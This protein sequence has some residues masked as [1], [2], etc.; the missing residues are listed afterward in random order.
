MKAGPPLA[1]I[2]VPFAANTLSGYPWDFSYSRRCG[3]ESQEG[4]RAKS[5]DC[6]AK[7]GQQRP[8]VHKEGKPLA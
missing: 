2:S 6:K 8:L 3:A 7:H 4:E 1:Q 5:I